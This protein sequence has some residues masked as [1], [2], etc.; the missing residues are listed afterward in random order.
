MSSG[1]LY[2]PKAYRKGKRRDHHVR[3]TEALR[4]DL[5]DL[6][7]VRAEMVPG[8]AH[9]SDSLVVSRLKDGMT[10]RNFQL[11]VKA[12]ALRAGLP[13]ESSPHWMRHTLAMNLIRRSTARSPLRIVQS[14]LGHSTL[15]STGIYTAPS[16]EEVDA[17]L[18][19]TTGADVRQRITRAQL[20]R[21]Y[22]SGVAR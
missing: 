13:P 5:Q 10:V 2:L 11:R 16:R 12:W 19:E 7:A 20:R 4:K 6:L 9:E 3:V 21:A 8:D 14:V 17:A 15:S 18:E 22:E 1:Y